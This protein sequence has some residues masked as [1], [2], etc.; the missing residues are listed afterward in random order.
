MRPRSR[1]VRLLTPFLAVAAAAAAAEAGTIRLYNDTSGADAY[2]NGSGGEFLAKI[3]GANPLPSMGAG[4]QIL[5]DTATYQTFQTFCLEHSEHFSPGTTYLWTISTGARNGGVSGQTTPNFDPLDATT[6]Y[7]YT[8]FWHGKLSNYDYVLG[9]SDR[10]L[11]AKELQN[12]IWYLEGERTLAQIG[13]TGTQAWTWIQEATA[14]TSV[15]GSWYQ[16]HGT[17]IGSVRVLNITDA[18]GN[19]KQ[20]QLFLVPL[21]PAAWLGLSTGLLAIAVRRRRRASPV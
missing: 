2:S 3:T 11:A 13:G 14:A 7:L 16:K 12:A 15:G 21:P 18:S 4:V 8:Q 17:G 5:P 19:P 10:S 6:A 9:S 20:D 1:L